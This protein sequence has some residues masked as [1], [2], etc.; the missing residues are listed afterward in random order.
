MYDVKDP[1]SFL[2]YSSLSHKYGLRSLDKSSL[3]LCGLICNIATTWFSW[4]FRLKNAGPICKT[5]DRV[6]HA[7]TRGCRLMR[8]QK[9]V[10]AG[11]IGVVRAAV[12]LS[13]LWRRTVIPQFGEN[14]CVR[15]RSS[16]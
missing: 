15:G 11:S 6:V 9:R 2:L 3:M 12:P 1:L 5:C 16:V 7:A 13:A 8:M 4:K 10:D 14:S